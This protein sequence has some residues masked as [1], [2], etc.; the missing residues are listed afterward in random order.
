MFADGEVGVV[1]LC[2]EEI[3]KGSWNISNLHAFAHCCCLQATVS[4]AGWFQ[5][6]SGGKWGRLQT[7]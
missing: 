5:A 2:Q 7:L 6:P 4:S 1:F 3:V